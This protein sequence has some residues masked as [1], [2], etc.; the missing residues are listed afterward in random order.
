MNFQEKH[1]RNIF[2]KFQSDVK[3][4]LEASA[5]ILRTT[6]AFIALNNHSCVRGCV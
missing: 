1:F 3:R 4:I 2:N 5:S 6:E